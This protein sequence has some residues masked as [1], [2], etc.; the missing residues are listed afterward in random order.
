MAP[1]GPM[2]PMAQGKDMDMGM[3]TVMEGKVL[4]DQGTDMEEEGLAKRTASRNFLNSVLDDLTKWCL[5]ENKWIMSYL[6][7]WN[8]V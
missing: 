3:G 2:G 4:V 1:M 6:T 5:L 7:K 8:L